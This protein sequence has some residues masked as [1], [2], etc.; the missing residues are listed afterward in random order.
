MKFLILFLYLSTLAVSSLAQKYPCLQPGVKE[1][2]VVAVLT[3]NSLNGAEKNKQ[4]TVRQTLTKLKAKCLK[5]K[6]VDVKRK[7]IRFY[8]LTGCWGN[9]PEGYLEI[10]AN[11]QKEI[12][13]LK[14][15]FK[16][17]EITCNANGSPLLNA[18]SRQ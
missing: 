12:A 6:L 9:P 11:Q 18:R 17:I 2:T 10:L 3:T 8:T 14:K 1:D 15:R 13:D 4:V 5:G 7:E 16:V